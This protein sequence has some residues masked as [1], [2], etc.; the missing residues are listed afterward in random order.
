[1]VEY[2]CLDI[3]IGY[4]NTSQFRFLKLENFNFKKIVFKI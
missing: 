1:M 3:Y 4:K 2:D